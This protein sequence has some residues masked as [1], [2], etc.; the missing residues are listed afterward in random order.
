MPKLCGWPFRFNHRQ[1]PHKQKPYIKTEI[2]AVLELKEGCC[3]SSLIQVGVS[4][5]GTPL[6]AIQREIPH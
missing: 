5:V 2:T 4:L 6:K 1:Q 3:R